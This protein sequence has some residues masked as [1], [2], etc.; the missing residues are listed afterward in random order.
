MTRPPQPATTNGTVHIQIRIPGWLKN[1]LITRATEL[2]T[3]INA[4]LVTAIK[5]WLEEDGTLPTPPP[6][7][8]P[9]PTT[10]DQIRAWAQGIKLTGPCGQTEC[11]A[12][13]GGIW[14]TDL[15]GFCRECGIRVV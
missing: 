7:A 13:T 10:A 6:A 15:M 14:E 3:S 1:K 12:R 4:L 2:D 5:K 11:S 8:H 9:L